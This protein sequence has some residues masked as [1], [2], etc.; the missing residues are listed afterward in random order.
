MGLNDALFS[1]K[2]AARP[3]HFI[4]RDMQLISMK[5]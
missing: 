3:L 5:M 2:P 4:R 1:I